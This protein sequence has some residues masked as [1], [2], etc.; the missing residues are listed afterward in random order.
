[1]QE[2]RARRGGS[3]TALPKRPLKLKVRL[4][5]YRH[6]RYAWR[7]NIHKA[8][9]D[10][11]PKRNFHYDD[12]TK[13]ELQVRLYFKEG[14][15]HSFIDVDNRLKDIMDALQGHV[16]GKGKKR[17]LKPIIPNDRQVYRVVVEKGPPPGQSHGLGHLVIAAYKG[18]IYRR[19]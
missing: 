8:V 10:R 15:K 5:P 18:P 6:P 12:N 2:N 9:L 17:K 16:G 1:M 14:K 7:K 3:K 19:L 11:L 13:F 4:P